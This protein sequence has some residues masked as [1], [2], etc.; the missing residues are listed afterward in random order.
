MKKRKVDPFVE[1]VVAQLK[2]ISNV[3]AKAMFGGY[4]LY[5]GEVFFAVIAESRLFFK[6][7][8][9]T[10]PRYRAVGSEMFNPTP[11]IKLK[12]YYEVPLAILESGPQLTEWAREAVEASQEKE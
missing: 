9:R 5:A 10:R 6:T 8:I 2:G 3:R 7:S 11:K 1:F 12:R 4:G